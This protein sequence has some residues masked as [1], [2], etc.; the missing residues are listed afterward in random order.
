MSDRAWN[1]KQSC[2]LVFDKYR[3]LGKP[4][5]YLSPSLVG[6]DYG[7]WQEV[8]RRLGGGSAASSSPP[9]STYKT[10][11]DCSPNLQSN[12]SNNLAY[13]A[14]L[15]RSTC[16][17]RLPTPNINTPFIDFQ[18]SNPAKHIK[19][20]LVDPSARLVS[21]QKTSTQPSRVS[22]PRITA[23]Q[24]KAPISLKNGVQ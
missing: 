22:K 23:G 7:R 8:G 10:L 4:A 1:E 18:T 11:L 21:K 2:Q 20:S 17:T 3:I 16:E 13:K 14:L 9:T 19:L 5:A 15:G 6:G 12:L 24:R